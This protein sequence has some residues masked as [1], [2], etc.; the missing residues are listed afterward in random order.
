MSS[1]RWQWTKC[2][3]PE[4]PSM[5]GRA[6]SVDDKRASAVDAAHRR[7]SWVQSGAFGAVRWRRKLWR[8]ALSALS[9]DRT[10][11]PA[12]PPPI[13][14]PGV[15][16]RPP[17]RHHPAGVDQSSPDLARKADLLARCV[18]SG[19][20]LDTPNRPAN[21]PPIPALAVDSRP[22]PRHHPAGVDQSSPDLA[23][24]ADLLGRFGGSRL[25]S[26]TR[27]RT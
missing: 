8:E 12:N 3:P 21:P 4:V 14:A 1:V 18:G 11:R 20:S 16:S 7:A 25:S 27:F 24:K 5:I 17:P 13:P 23:R 2:S 15:D 9:L 26:P 19:L 22:P 6:R 10:N